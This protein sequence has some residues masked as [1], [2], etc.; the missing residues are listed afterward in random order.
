MN[1]QQV[2]AFCTIVS[3]GSFSR[4]AE[5]LGLTQPTI[6]AQ[7]Q[8]LEKGLRSRLFERSAQGI[9]LTQA[10]QEFHKYAL[11]LIDLTGRAEQ[12]MEELQGLTR[13]RLEL[14]ASTVPGQYLLPRALAI[15]KSRT[16]GVQ[17][18][19]HVSNTQEIRHGVREGRFELGMVGEK[20]RDERLTY[21][22]ITEEHLRVVMRPEHPLAGRATLTLEEF[23][24]QPLIIRE[25]GSGTRATLEH[26]V[27]GRGGEPPSQEIFLELSSAEAIK[28]AIRSVDAVAVLSEWSVQEEERLGLLKTAA[29]EGVDLSRSIY[30]TWR[31]HGYLSVATEAF[32][33]FLR[34]EYLQQARDR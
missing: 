25:W 13:G 28:T 26:A 15:F 3:E 10:G 12:A 8:S 16:P 24:A 21:A 9:S 23:R 14:G 31:S 22:P 32:V 6:S 30:L 5:R 17:V 4:A 20:V 29:I 18:S 7:I 11:Q 34:E 27:A 2:R 33:R 19:L 1:F